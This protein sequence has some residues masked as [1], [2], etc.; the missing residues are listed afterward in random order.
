M[1]YPIID[2]I[3]LKS[4]RADVQFSQKKVPAVETTAGRP[5]LTNPKLNETMHALVV[6]PAYTTH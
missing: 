3:P 2:L 1:I 5:D 6:N 4:C